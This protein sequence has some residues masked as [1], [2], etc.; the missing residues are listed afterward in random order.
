[1]LSGEISLSPPSIILGETSRASLARS[2]V[3]CAECVRGGEPA[4]S[5]DWSLSMLVL[6]LCSL[7]RL[8]CTGRC[9]F[10]RPVLGQGT[11]AN[12]VCDR[13]HDCTKEQCLQSFNLKEEERKNV[14]EKGYGGDTLLCS[15]IIAFASL[16]L[17][18]NTCIKQFRQKSSLSLYTLG[19]ITPYITP[20]H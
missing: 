20:Q 11:V 1:M 12:Y 13:T 7:F 6:T 2:G 17:L 9:L 14:R 19:G 5:S 3:R 8:A 15:L 18:D 10:R 16:Y 4:D